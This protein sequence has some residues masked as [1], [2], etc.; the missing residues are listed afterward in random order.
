MEAEASEGYVI[1]TL[2]YEREGNKWVGTCHELSTSTFART[3]RRKNAQAMPAE[4]TELVTEHLDVLEQSGQRERFF[5]DWG[6]EF[7]P[8]YATPI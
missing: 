2:K 4:L 8:V 6:I 1:L 3:L 7:H 5:R